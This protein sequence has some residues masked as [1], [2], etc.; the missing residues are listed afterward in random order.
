[1]TEYT[2]PITY[3]STSDPVTMYYH[4]ILQQSDKEQFL[5]V[6][7]LEISNHNTKRHWEL[8]KCSNILQ[9]YRVLPSV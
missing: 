1:M 6:M 4:E 9:G 2:N 5:D 3:K 8:I 7:Q